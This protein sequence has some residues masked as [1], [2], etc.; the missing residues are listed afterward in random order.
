MDG[1]VARPRRRRVRADCRRRVQ[2]HWTAIAHLRNSRD[3]TSQHHD[4]HTLSGT[5]VAACDGRR[6][7]KILIK[8]DFQSV[9]E[10]AGTSLTNGV[11]KYPAV[12]DTAEDHLTKGKWDW[13]VEA[14]NSRQRVRLLPHLTTGT[15]RSLTS[16]VSTA[17]RLHS[18]ATPTAPVSGC[19]LDIMVNVSNQCSGRAVDTGAQ[20]GAQSSGASYY[21]GLPRP[22]TAS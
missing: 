18:T 10:Y 8:R 5:D 17:G 16:R 2:R 1:A 22:T 4:G 7:H 19:T 13:L 11:Y 3:D 21:L 14:Y 9:Y 12:T 20:L 6:L 15:S